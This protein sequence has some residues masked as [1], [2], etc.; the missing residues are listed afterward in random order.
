[1][2]W[3]LCASFNLVSAA[4]I[5]SFLSA[6]ILS[7]NSLNCFSVWKIRLSAW[8][9]FS[10]FSRASLSVASLAFASAFIFSISSL[11]K[12]LPAS[13]LIFCSLPVP[14]S[15]A[16]TLKIPFASISKVTSIWG[17]PLG[18]GGIPSKLKIPKLLFWLAIGRS[19]CNTWIWT[20]GWLS[21]AVEYTSVFLVGMVVLEGI[22]VV[23]TLPMV[24]IPRPSG[25]TSNNNTSFTSPVNT[26][27][28]IAAPSATTSSGLTPRFGFLP[29]NFSTISCTL[30]IRVEPPTKIISSISEVL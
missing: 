16:C 21:L 14:L 27:P 28:W 12:P 29:K 20:P 4:S 26:A 1:M 11:L 25:V 6:E 3:F 10:T 30:G 13:I 18:A 9:N 15:F 22:M 8:F 24:S 17:T 19:P 7:P 23:I 2:S 5:G